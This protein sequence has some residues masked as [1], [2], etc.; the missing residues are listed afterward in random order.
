ML[1]EAPAGAG[2]AAEVARRLVGDAN[3]AGGSDNVTAVV[4]RFL[5]APGVRPDT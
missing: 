4:A 3:D 2:G 5:E 1:G